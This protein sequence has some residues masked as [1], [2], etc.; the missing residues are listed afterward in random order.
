MPDFVASQNAG[1]LVCVQIEDHEAIGNIDDILAIEGIDVF[2]IGP[3]DLSQSMG[4]PG[5]PKAEP[6]ARAIDAT[7]ARIVAAGR[8]PGMPA[9][10]EAL[11]DV[12]GR[13]CRYVYNHLPRLLGAG[14]ADYIR[15]AARR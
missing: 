9:T 7:L 12:V 5:N 11:P 2:F 4:F 13:G 8:A 1:S 3:S 14:A 15:A 6:V 10:T